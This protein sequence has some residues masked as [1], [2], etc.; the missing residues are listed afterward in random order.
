[1]TIND[2][3]SDSNDLWWLLMMDDVGAVLEYNI[4][5]LQRI[6]IILLFMMENDEAFLWVCEMRSLLFGIIIY[7][8]EHT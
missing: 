3:F 5:Q 4:W 1:M 2:D 6:V 8:I 7:I